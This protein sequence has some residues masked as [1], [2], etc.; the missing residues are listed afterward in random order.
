MRW[1]ARRGL[2]CALFVLAQL[3]CAGFAAIPITA[4][5]I[6]LE[7]DHTRIVLESPSP[8]VFRLVALRRRVVLELDDIEF[9]RDFGALPS[10]LDSA[11]PYISSIKIG[12]SRRRVQVQID[13]KTDAEPRVLSRALGAGRGYALVL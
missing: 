6:Q 5:R 13:L 1:G 9:G 3:P 7:Q 4:A 12:G 2:G 11:H 10:R 8:P